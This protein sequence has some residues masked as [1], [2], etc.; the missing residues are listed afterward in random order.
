M[1]GASLF[2]SPDR[3][4]ALIPPSQSDE[5]APGTIFSPDVVVCRLE[6]ESG[7][8]VG[9]DLRCAPAVA[10]RWRA[11]L[12]TQLQRVPERLRDVFSGHEPGGRP[13]DRPHLALLPVADVGRPRAEGRLEGLGLVLPRALAA[14]DA[15]LLIEA[16]AR[17]ERLVLGRL[18]VWRLAAVRTGE[19]APAALRPDGWTAYPSGA[20]RWSTVTPMAFDRHPK[21]ADAAAHH[22]EMA[23]MVADACARVGLPRPR[24]VAVGAASVHAG[25]P[26]AHVFPRLPR[27]DGSE[28]R[29]AHVEVAFDGP[30][31]GPVLI[32]A[33]RYR[34]YGVC[35]AVGVGV[36]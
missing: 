35:R 22:E 7:A 13:L 14:D 8:G 16:A 36:S 3:N 20:V 26:P 15:R 2:R 23:A 10:Q 4:Q 17:V 18:G 21:A 19:H 27:K 24:E 25:V 6:P 28:R 12:L 32:G 29:H 33:G 5:P 1:H 31:C 30:V 11:A 9:L 34:G